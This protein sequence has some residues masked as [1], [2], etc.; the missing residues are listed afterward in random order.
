M[1][2][3]RSVSICNGVFVSRA[4]RARIPAGFPLRGEAA[5]AARSD[6]RRPAA[7]AASTKAAGAR[8][9]RRRCASRARKARARER[10][11]HEERR[12][13]RPIL[14]VARQPAAGSPPRAAPI[15]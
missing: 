5:P 15:V 12:A 11:L 7:S 13:A 9:S 1:R 8:G 10:L 6:A 2:A 3:A 14:A 4:L